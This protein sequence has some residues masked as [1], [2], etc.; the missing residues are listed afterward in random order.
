MNF[1]GIHRGMSMNDM[2]TRLRR[3]LRY[4]HYDINKDSDL[5]RKYNEFSALLLGGS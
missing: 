3:N 1:C 5:H 4:Y 2:K